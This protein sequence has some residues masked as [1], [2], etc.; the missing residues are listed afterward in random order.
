[1]IAL[2]QGRQ[3]HPEQPLHHQVG[4]AVGA[5]TVALHGHGMGMIQHAGAARFPDEALTRARRGEK[6][7]MQHLD[8]DDFR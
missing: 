4:L 6:V 5:A 3:R 7:L 8:R 1:M 2:Q